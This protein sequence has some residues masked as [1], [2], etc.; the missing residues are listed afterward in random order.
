MTLVRAALAQV[1]PALLL[2]LPALAE[3]VVDDGSGADAARRRRS[4][5]D[6]VEAVAD[7]AA[8]PGAARRP[9]GRGAAAAHVVGAR[10]PSR[11]RPGDRRPS[12]HAPTPTDEPLDLPAL[13]S[14]RSRSSPDGGTSHRAR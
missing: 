6:V 4:D 13:L 1:D 10:G 5:L 2:V 12:L 3:V 14:R 11:G 9:A 8:G 7:R